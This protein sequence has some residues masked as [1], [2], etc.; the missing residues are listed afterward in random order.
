MGWRSTR[1]KSLS[2]MN[3]LLLLLLL[4]IN[5]CYCDRSKEE[6][7]TDRNE[8]IAKQKELLSEIGSNL[9]CYR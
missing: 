9:K 7:L 8:N 3:L 2:P 4:V 6:V 5:T 1:I